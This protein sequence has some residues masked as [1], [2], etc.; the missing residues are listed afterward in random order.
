M[1][2]GSLF[3]VG[4]LVLAASP[5]LAQDPEEQLMRGAEWE[6][7]G[8]PARAAEAYDR[9][10][11]H[12]P[13]DEFALCRLGLLDFH[14]RR[15]GDARARFEAVLAA[16][17]GN[18]LARSMR[19]MLLLREGKNDAA[20]EDFEAALVRD[21]AAVLPNLGL[22]AVL[23]AEGREAEALDRLAAARP[24]AGDD[25]RLLSAWRDMSR[26]LGL[27]MAARLA[28]DELVELA[29]RDPSALVELGWSL[30]A[31]REDELARNA[32]RQALR[33]APGDAGAR[34]ALA[35]SLRSDAAVLREAGEEKR[36]E[37]FLREAEET[38]RG[39]PTR[40]APRQ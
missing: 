4:V 34:K 5:V 29:P 33:L 30:R 20:R 10:L 25:P 19:G 11:A 13:G 37:R 23:L 24:L 31:L 8:D 36:A 27:P 1:R 17:P 28:Q 40:P 35:G 39:G 3:L 18:I 2:A 22:A 16:N 6:A 14:A 26:G 9:A 38:E 21:G 7:R 15:P 32:W 12:R